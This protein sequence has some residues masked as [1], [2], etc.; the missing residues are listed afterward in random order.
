MATLVEPAIRLLLLRGC[1][2][3]SAILAPPVASGGH[4]ESDALVVGD[5]GA[6][7]AAHDVSP[8][9]ALI[10]VFLP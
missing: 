6:A 10:A 8:V 7:L 2:F 9:L 3:G 4:F 1:P 5:L